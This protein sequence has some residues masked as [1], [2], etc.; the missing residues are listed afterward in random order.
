MTKV[1]EVTIIVRYRGAS[2][3]DYRVEQLVNISEP[4]VGSVISKTKLDT[5]INNTPYK[6]VVKEYRP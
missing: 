5:L 4:R 1:K 2:E 3:D 6:I